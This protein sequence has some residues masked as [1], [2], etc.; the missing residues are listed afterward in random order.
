MKKNCC[1]FIFRKFKLMEEGF[2]YTPAKA[3]VRVK[4]LFDKTFNQTIKS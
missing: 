3:L 2:K 4:K 1:F